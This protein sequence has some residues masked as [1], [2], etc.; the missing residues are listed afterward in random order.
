[1]KMK[2]AY[3]FLIFPVV[4][5]L[6]GFV[7]LVT[8]ND[9]DSDYIS[10]IVEVTD[11]DV[12][13]KIPGRID[14]VFVSEG[15][16]VKRGQVLARLEGKEISAKVEQ[17]V[18]LKNAAKARY[19]MARNGARKEEKEALEKLWFQAK[20]QFELAEKTYNRIMKMYADSLISLQEK[21]QYE[22]QYRA[23]REQMEAAGAKYQMA[24]NGAR[25]EEI[26]MA[27]SAYYQAE[28]G[29]LEAMAYKDELIIKSPV[30]GELQKRIVDPGEIISAGYPV[31]TIL[32]LNDVWVTIRIKEDMMG[33][34]TKGKIVKG[35]VPAMNNAEFEFIVSY[36]APM[37][38]YA[39][40]KPTNQKGD[41]D[42][43]TFEIRLRGR[44]EI[45]GLRPGMTVNFKI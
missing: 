37:A 6:T 34:I 2:K 29:Y 1:M 8:G 25:F 15:E 20:H 13:S 23:A 5:A 11:I 43:R 35:K 44:N 17:T 31:F 21:D 18:G 22:F 33:S 14:S 12:A 24:L 26:D 40:W 28:N 36:I 39:N 4:L 16:F 27:E 38:D 19:N 45:K 10:G 41:F 42:I 32:D 30:T 9:Q 7:V 3:L